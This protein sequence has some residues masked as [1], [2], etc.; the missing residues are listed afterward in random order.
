MAGIIGHMG[1]FTQKKRGLYIGNLRVTKRW[2][3]FTYSLILGK[4]TSGVFY[5]IYL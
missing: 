3:L 4:I 2:S 1:H 5:L